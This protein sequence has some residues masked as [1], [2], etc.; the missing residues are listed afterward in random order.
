MAAAATVR[1]DILGLLSLEAL[2]HGPSG[3]ETRII[4]DLNATLQEIYSLLP[5]NWWVNDAR[6]ALVRAPTSCSVTVTA[7]AQTITFV[8]PSYSAWM[9]G[10]S[11]V[12]AGDAAQNRIVVDAGASP[13]LL[14]PFQG[15]TGTVAATL[16]QDVVQCG[17]E[18]EQ[19]M[20]PVQ[21]EGQRELIG[22]AHHRELET[23]GNEPP[24]PLYP[25]EWGQRP[26]QLPTSYLVER[27]TIY[28]TSLTTPRIRFNSLPDQAL[29]LNYRAKLTGL[30]VRVTAL[31][32]SRDYLVPFAYTESILLPLVRFRFSTWPQFTG[33][34][35]A[36]KEDAD[37]AKA[38][39]QNLNP[40][41][42]TPRCVDVGGDW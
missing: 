31:D 20:G 41:G 1:D 29:V 3:L 22:L 37:A 33:D 16:Y 15:T 4:N 5:K 6:A 32:D 35:A 10:C 21:F 18:V 34:R 25:M 30:P 36:L 40:Q 11:I 9:G 13:T 27:H 7:D 24:V 14:K 42:Y 19:V 26:V 38:L 8:S 28:S 12:I 39:L 23:Y 17:S 2:S